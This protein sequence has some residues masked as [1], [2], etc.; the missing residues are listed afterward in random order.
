MKAHW[1]HHSSTAHWVF[2]PPPT[3]SA[4]VTGYIPREV[5]KSFRPPTQSF[6]ALT[7]PCRMLLLQSTVRTRAMLP[8]AHLAQFS[9][10]MPSWVRFVFRAPAGLTGE[11]GVR[12]SHSPIRRRSY[13]AAYT[14]ACAR[15]NRRI[16]ST[17]CFPFSLGPIERSGGGCR[18]GAH[19]GAGVRQGRERLVE[20]V[21]GGSWRKRGCGG[22]RSGFR[23]RVL[24]RY[25]APPSGARVV[26]R[27]AT[28]G[29]FVPLPLGVV[30]LCAGWCVW[31]RAAVSV[32]IESYVRGDHFNDRLGSLW[33]AP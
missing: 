11:T 8:S 4:I 17:I 18:G 16:H 29:E 27:F 9:H 22:A 30:D 10:G 19:P 28:P 21:R 23:G 3:A 32:W 14:F 31:F 25:E 26:H 6:R 2:H 7:S 1:P 33:M 12:C 15:G 5:V 13:R 20:L 24:R